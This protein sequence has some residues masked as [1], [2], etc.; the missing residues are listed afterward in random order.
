MLI[1]LLRKKEPDRSKSYFYLPSFVKD[2]FA[3]KPKDSP[4]LSQY[5]LPYNIYQNTSGFIFLG[6]K[7]NENKLLTLTVKQTHIYTYF[8]S[9]VAL[10]SLRKREQ[11]FWKIINPSIFIESFFENNFFIL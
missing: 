9:K 3:E 1:P 8:D 7:Q 5:R 4:K 6:A 2:V 10:V 11:K